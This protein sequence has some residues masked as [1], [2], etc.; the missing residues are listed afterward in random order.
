M[1]QNLLSGKVLSDKELEVVRLLAAG[2]QLKQ[3]ATRLNIGLSAVSMR[4]RRAG[5]LLGTTTAVHTVVTC[6]QL[7]LL[8]PDTRRV[9]RVRRALADRH[10]STCAL[11]R[12][13]LCDCV[14][15]ATVSEPVSYGGDLVV[16]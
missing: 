11:L 4:L 13:P 6:A 16:L 5:D 3:V 7:G 9:A 10:S 1:S 15:S 8:N 14:E 2:L 12:P